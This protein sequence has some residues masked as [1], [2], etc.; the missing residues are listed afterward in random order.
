M[1][2]DDLVERV[3]K[4]FKPAGRLTA[5]DRRQAAAAIA[6]VRPAVLIEVAERAE[7]VADIPPR[8]Y[9][10]INVKSWQAGLTALAGELRQEAAAAAAGSS[11]AT[12][13]DAQKAAHCEPSD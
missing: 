3:A 7:A 9:V 12:G 1:T 6:L 11:P 10:T 13:S 5:L 8:L 4:A 2:D